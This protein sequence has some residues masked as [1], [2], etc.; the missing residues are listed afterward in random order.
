[1][2]RGRTHT[3]DRCH[4]VRPSPVVNLKTPFTER[5]QILVPEPLLNTPRR[6][7][8]L[9]GLRAISLVCVLLAH[10]SG[11][12]HFLRWEVLEIYG[13][14]GVRIFFVISGYLITS[15]LLKEHERSGAISLKDFYIR[16]AYRILPAAYVF[17]GIVIATRWHSI[18]SYNVLAAVTY[19]SN[20]FHGGEWT[21][22]HLWSLSVEEQF[23]LLWPAMLAGMFR[24]RI[25][26][27]GTIFALAPLM[28]VSFWILWGHRGLEHP[29]PVVMDALAAGCALAMIE[30]HLPRYDRWL[31]SPCFVLVPVVTIL[32]PLTQIHHNR[33]YQGVGLSAIYL[34]I[35]LSIA[36]AVRMEYRALNWP[37][38]AWLGMMSYSFYLWQQ[39]FL[40]RGSSSWWTAFPQNLA[41]SLGCAVL[42][43]YGVEKPFLALRDRRKNQ[44]ERS[45]GKKSVANQRT[46]VAIRKTA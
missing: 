16:R 40:N 14:F 41:L 30:S 24:K 7:P 46:R 44:I 15:L 38:V 5:W 10:L 37:P 13:G 8:S 35:A 2:T 32:L 18:A 4:N 28:R 45:L 9:D 43:Y 34:G 42:S 20:Y 26:L 33:I 17:M 6:I 19:T 21:L 39:P 25:W 12:R 23:Y 29:F 36:H 31:R 27:A 22:G 3:S 11:T 1:V